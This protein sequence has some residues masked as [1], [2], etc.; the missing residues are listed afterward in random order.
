MR[1]R[2]IKQAT[3]EDCLFRVL[4]AWCRTGVGQRTHSLK[5]ITAFVSGTGVSAIAPLLDVF[6][7]DGNSADIIF[8][9]DRNGTDREAVKQLFAL[10]RAYIKQIDVRVFH[11]PSAGAIF[12]PK[13]FIYDR[14]SE[15]DFVVGSSNLTSGGLASNF[16]SLLLYEK[17]PRNSHIGADALSIWE[18]FSHP[19]RP[20]SA[21][22]LRELT[23]RDVKKLLAIL[24]ERT[25]LEPRSDNRR[26]R[27][28]WKPLSRIRLPRS[29]RIRLRRRYQSVKG[30]QYL[31]MDLLEET[32]HTQVQIPLPVVE[33]FFEIEKD[34]PA[35]ISISVLTSAG[36]TQPIRRPIVISGLGY[37]RLMRRLE[38]PQIKGMK[39]PLAV[40]F[41]K[42]KGKAE[43]A[44][45][46]LERKSPQYSNADKLLDRHGRQGGFTRRYMIGN[47][48]DRFW[49][50][51]SQ[52]LP[53]N[54]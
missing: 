32:R 47:L 16:E 34:K 17:V 46:L 12:H 19:K 26:I 29:G 24:P 15:I 39:R 49:A 38:M 10:K 50:R 7:A 41:V 5:V 44:Y 20:L 30:R 52:L 51:V 9:V 11:A 40:V 21:R 27:K 35:D 23:H 18:T 8:G 48:R 33:R 36:Q 25:A 54:L 31:L 6:L 42:L 13:L 2:H 3:T 45:S 1:T 4:E 14:G 43:Y 37:G 53:E 22:F 28:L